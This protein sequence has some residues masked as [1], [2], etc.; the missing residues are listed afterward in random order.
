VQ[1]LVWIDRLY[2]SPLYSGITVLGR[3]FTVLQGALLIGVLLWNL[4]MSGKEVTN[5]DGSYIP[6]VPRVLLYLGY[7]LLLATTSLLFGSAIDSPAQSAAPPLF[8]STNW[9]QLGIQVLGVPLLVAGFVI[10]VIRW[11]ARSVPNT[12]DS[13]IHQVNQA[14]VPFETAVE[15]SIGKTSNPQ[16]LPTLVQPS[17]TANLR[18]SPKQWVISWHWVI[19]WGCLAGLLGVLS[20]CTEVILNQGMST[21]GTTEDFVALGL[22]AYLAALLIYLNL[23]RAISRAACA[24]T[25]G[26]VG[27]LVASLVGWCFYVIANL[28]AVALHFHPLREIGNGERVRMF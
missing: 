22:V 3:Q 5:I 4:L 25:P 13:A 10:G 17:R 9:T 21:D 28:T 20:V 23:A 12:T 15:I 7:I 8:G 14:A 24:K 19:V 1:V 18:I 6:R 27:A 16:Y 2:A 26:I 11:R